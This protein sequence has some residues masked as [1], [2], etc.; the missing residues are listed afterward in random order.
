MSRRGWL[1]AVGVMKERGTLA[2]LALFCGVIVTLSGAAAWARRAPTE[3]PS[4]GQEDVGTDPGTGALLLDLDDG[5]SDDEWAGARDAI[6]RGVA[7]FDFVVDD[8]PRDELG[9]MLSDEAELYRIVVPATEAT[10]W[11]RITATMYHESVTYNTT[12]E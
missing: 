9:E 4:A 1:D 2:R 10:V 3:P 5:A 12:R 7:P 6:A 8:S 11:Y